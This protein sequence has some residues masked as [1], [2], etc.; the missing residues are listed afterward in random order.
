MLELFPM[1][2][3][4]LMTARKSAASPA[5]AISPPK[6]AGREDASARKPP[7]IDG[8]LL[9]RERASAT[10]KASRESHRRRIEI[11]EDKIK[12]TPET[13]T[14]WDRADLAR[15]RRALARPTRAGAPARL[16]Q[17]HKWIAIHYFWER[18]QPRIDG[19][20]QRP[21]AAYSKVREH[22]D[23]E[24]TTIVKAIQKHET[25]ARALA[26]MSDIKPLIDDKASTFRQLTVRKV[27]RPPQS[28]KKKRGAKYQIDSLG[29]VIDPKA[30]KP[31]E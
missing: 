6:S 24:Q 25:D 22:W 8:S 20:L 15:A 7:D 29:F 19:K 12:R 21:K 5:G 27:S 14:R 23:V 2:F 9:R 30:E 13:V 3:E 10:L 18:A 4:N 16:V 1:R 17:F 11:I 28:K 26:V 31:R